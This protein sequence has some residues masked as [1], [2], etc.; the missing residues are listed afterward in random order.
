MSPSGLGEL[1]GDVA[2]LTAMGHACTKQHE[3]KQEKGTLA[4]SRVFHTCATDISELQRPRHAIRDGSGYICVSEAPAAE[5]ALPTAGKVL[6][7][8]GKALPAVGTWKVMRSPR[9]ENSFGVF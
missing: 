3:V 8:A 4:T 6:P 1:G 7:P 2:A 5:R 9:S